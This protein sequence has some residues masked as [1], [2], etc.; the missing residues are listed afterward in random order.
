VVTAVGITRPAAV[1]VVSH[2]RAG[3]ASAADR[4]VHAVHALGVDVYYAGF[5]F[6]TEQARH[7]LPGTYLGVRISDAADRVVAGSLR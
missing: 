6:A 5:S 2:S 3:T 7:G 4:T 1:V